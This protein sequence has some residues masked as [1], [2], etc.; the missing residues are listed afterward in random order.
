MG[1]TNQRN[2]VS[3]V[4]YLRDIDGLKNKLNRK[5]KNSVFLSIYRVKDGHKKP[6]GEMYTQ[7]DLDFLKTPNFF[8]DFHSVSYR[9]EV[10][11]GDY[12]LIPCTY[13]KD[14]EGRFYIDLFYEAWL[15]KNDPIYKGY[16]CPTNQV[17]ENSIMSQ[18][19]TSDPSRSLGRGYGKT[20]SKACLIM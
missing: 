2:K 5:E 1:D 13:E 8:F 11:P 14:Q 10:A 9:L 19:P 15:D 12:V 20:V 7:A 4:L 16:D 17:T 3:I 6:E 18:P